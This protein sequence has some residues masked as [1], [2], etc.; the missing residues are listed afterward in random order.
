MILNEVETTFV[1]EKMGMNV[2]VGQNVIFTWAQEDELMSWEYYYD[3]NDDLY[4]EAVVVEGILNKMASAHNEMTGREKREA[5]EL[6]QL[7]KVG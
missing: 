3:K 7:T 4:P 2:E 1:K 6:A 5:Q